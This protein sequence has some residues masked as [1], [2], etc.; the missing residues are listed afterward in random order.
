MEIANLRT[1]LY[2]CLARLVSPGPPDPRILILSRF[3][4]RRILIYTE[5]DTGQTQSLSS[6]YKRS[7]FGRRAWP[8]RRSLVCVQVALVNRDASVCACTPREY[9]PV[10]ARSPTT[11]EPFKFLV[12]H[13]GL[14]ADARVLVAFEPSPG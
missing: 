3:W 11:R 2:L 8:G 1:F 4:S 13:T 9:E 5:R 6:P 14:Y 10:V 7:A 12:V